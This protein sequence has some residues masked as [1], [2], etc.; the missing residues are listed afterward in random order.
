[1]RIGAR[2]SS[3]VFPKTPRSRGLRTVLTL[4]TLG[5]LGAS[6][7]RQ[8]NPATSTCSDIP[9]PAQASEGGGFALEFCGT[10]GGGVDRV[11][12]AIDDPQS[13]GPGPALDVGGD[14]TLEW[15]MKAAVARNSTDEVGGGP[16][17][18]WISG[19][20]LF[21]RDRFDQGRKFGVSIAGGK[22]TFGVTGAVGDDRTIVGQT[23]VTD[24]TW[25]HVAV[26]RRLADGRLTIHV[27]GRLEA[28]ALGPQG[29]ISYPDD[30][31]P[32]DR[33]GGPC[34][35]SDPFLVIGAEKHDAGGGW[36]GYNGLLDEVRVSSTVRYA[37]TFTAP[38]RRFEPDGQTVALWHF[39]EGKGDMLVDSSTHATNGQLFV[40]GP[41]RAPR[42]VPSDAP[43]D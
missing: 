17:L 15:W 33:C 9:R 34:T 42:W 40:G 43:L 32:L 4:L 24:G 2:S 36:P 39:D 29:D 7:T 41:N 23:N 20:I 37:G 31:V 1:M 6:C 14:M 16:N 8:T 38:T 28:E 3:V 19:N 10:Q 22:V 5:G 11:K 12:I 27:D 30:A 13:D 21:D 25:H 35:N 18:D 26:Q